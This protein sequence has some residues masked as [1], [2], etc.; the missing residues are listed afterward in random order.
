MG[1]G[2]RPARRRRQH[3]AVARRR[4]AR[5]VRQRAP[6]DARA[7]GPHRALGRRAARR[8]AT[9]RICRRARRSPTAGASARPMRCSRWPRTTPCRRRARS[10]TRISTSR[11]DFT[12]T[13][14]LQ[15]IEVRP[16][17]RALVHHILVYY[18]APPDGR[19]PRRSC[20]PNRDAQSC[21]RGE[22]RAAGRRSG[23]A[24][25]RRLLATY[26]PGTDPQVFPR[27]TALRLPPGGV[28]EFQMH[29][30][31]QRHGRHRPVEGRD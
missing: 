18:Q 19:V 10:I 14:W 17:N 2:D 26:A 31:D 6:A 20:V 7:E 28:L 29:Y 1:A 11:P 22:S 21:C 16:G 24:A 30:T 5:H 13:K 9:P 4:T 15:A 23:R 3:A 25:R 12:E 27:G 8:R